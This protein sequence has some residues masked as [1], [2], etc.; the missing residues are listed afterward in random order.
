MYKILFG[1]WVVAMIWMY[2]T[3]FSE[4]QLFEVD[5]KVGFFCDSES[6][7]NRVMERLT[8]YQISERDKGAEIALWECFTKPR[9]TRLWGS[10]R[11]RQIITGVLLGERAVRVRFDGQ[12]EYYWT[13][14]TWVSK[15]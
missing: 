15:Y 1:G 13:D 14:L 6:K 10:M 9:G 4:E 12:S 8:S 5:Q 11:L 3:G 7:M 2:N